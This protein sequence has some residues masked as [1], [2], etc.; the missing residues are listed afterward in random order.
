MAVTLTNTAVFSAKPREK[1]YKLFDGQGLFLNVTPTG[2]KLWRLKYR[3][4]GKEK[5]LSLGKY[6]EISLATARELAFEARKQLSLGV[7]PGAAK[8]AA[9]AKA[10]EDGLTFATVAEEWYVKRAAAVAEITSRHIRHRLDKFLLPDLGNLPIKSIVPR[11][12]LTP[13]RRVEERGHAHSARRA[14]QIC[15]QVFR[16]GVAC[17]Y[18]ESDPTRDLR[19]ALTMETTTHQ[20]SITEPKSVGALLRAIWD[21]EGSPVVVL[22]LR[23]A[24]YVFVRPGELRHAEWSEIDF[25]AA[26]WRI[27][28]AKMKMRQTHIVPLAK[29]TLEVLAEL[30]P[31]TGKGR[32]LFPS[33]R[34][35]LRPISN[36]TLNAALRRMG[37]SKDE[38]VAH[39]F[40][41]MA[42]TLLNEQGWNRDAIER[43]LAHAEGNS[44]R[45]A[46][47]YAEHLPERRKMMQAY[48]DHLDGLRLGA[49]VIRLSGGQ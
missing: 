11:Q 18:V 30:H 39:G 17:G 44:V 19:G 3:F 35:V 27:P 31:F 1:A 32:Y 14:L 6:P 43:Q 5:L 42:S 33:E 49:K 36:G 34:T 15:G 24:V 41:S 12:I 48:A 23:M 47:N 13:L 9:K 22:A 45:R 40:R 25:D 26:E 4:G 37:Y 8:Q 20:Q 28:A 10:V 46:Y 2:G 38:I 21:Y 29:Q 16:Y 7:D